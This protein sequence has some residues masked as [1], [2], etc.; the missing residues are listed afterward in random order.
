MKYKANQ[1]EEGF[2]PLFPFVHNR[3]FCNFVS[4]RQSA[5]G[6]AEERPPRNS[7]SGTLQRVWKVDRNV[8][9]FSFTR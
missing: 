7:L 6:N 4:E 1:E 8:D 3:D 2:K 5:R 9:L